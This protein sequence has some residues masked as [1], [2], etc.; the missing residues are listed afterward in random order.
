MIWILYHRF[1][2]YIRFHLIYI[3]ACVN[4]STHCNIK[5]CLIYVLYKRGEYLLC[6]PSTQRF[7]NY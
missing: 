6:P 2:A 3:L 4:N 1:V 7:Y 5:Q